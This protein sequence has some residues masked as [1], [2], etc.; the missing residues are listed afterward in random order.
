[1]RDSGCP[2]TEAQI[3]LLQTCVDR[4]TVNDHDLA[5]VLHVSPHTV[6][7]HFKHI[8]ELLNVHSRFAAVLVAAKR[9]WIGIYGVPVRKIPRTWYSIPS[10]AMLES[11][12]SGKNKPSQTCEEGKRVALKKTFYSVQGEIIGEKAAGGQ[13]VDYLTDALGSVVGTVNQSAQV[14]NT[15]RYKPFGGLLAKTGAGADPAFQWV[16]SPGYRNSGKKWSDVYIRARHYDSAGG[17]WT[18]RDPVSSAHFHNAFYRYVLQSPILLSDPSG[19]RVCPGDCCADEKDWWDKN[20][21]HCGHGMGKWQD[22]PSIDK[23][24][25]RCKDFKKSDKECT[26]L[27]SVLDGIAFWCAKMC[28]GGEYEPGDQWTGAV[29]CCS[30]KVTHVWKY[31]EGPR[32]CSEDALIKQ[33]QQRP[34]DACALAC[35]V[36]HEEDHKTECSKGL[37]ISECCAY[38]DQMACLIGLYNAHCGTYMSNT[39]YQDCVRKAVRF[40]CQRRLSQAPSS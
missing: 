2:L 7:T 27:Q 37:P 13:R 22:C 1:M 15:Y 33:W 35:L 36:Q 8:L 24:K 25:D 32:C 4:L 9:E 39:D 21:G 19:L 17:S 20:I 18:T 12:R 14:I 10:P 30:D 23:L 29:H 5:A 31:C 16:G 26:Y 3:Q 6:H 28:G 11:T 38:R 34:A 40:N